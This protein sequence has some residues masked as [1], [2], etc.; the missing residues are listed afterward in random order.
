[1]LAQEAIR[2]VNDP[3]PGDAGGINVEDGKAGLLFGGQRVGVGLGDAQLLQPA[4]HRGRKTAFAGF[5]LRAQAIE[6]HLRAASLGLMQHAGV[7]RG[8]DQV[9]R[10][11]DGMDIAGQ[12]QVEI[13][14]RD[15]L[16]V[17]AAGR[18]ALD[19]EGRPLRRLTDRCYDALAQQSQSL[20]Q[21]HRSRRLALA[22][23]RR[24]DSR[25][26]NVL[27][28]R[29]VLELFEDI[30]VHFGLVFAVRLDVVRAEAQ[31][32]DDLADRLQFGRLRDFQVAGDGRQSLH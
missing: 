20:S 19:A 2:D 24:C 7:N 32:G 22:Q 31:R 12:M 1:M 14:H 6:H 27:A 25:D 5:V 29:P 17:A 4:Q 15:D 16:A 23:R 21:A 11:S 9:V 8:R 3:V 26:V 18:A 13:F 30:E 28:L 10:S